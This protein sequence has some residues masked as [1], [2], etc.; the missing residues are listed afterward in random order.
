VKID[1]EIINIDGQPVFHLNLDTVKRLLE[2]QVGTMVAVEIRSPGDDLTR[3]VQL[4]RQA[5]PAT[6][7]WA[8]HQGTPYWY[9][10]ITGF[11]DTTPHYVDQ[12]IKDMTEK[13]AKGI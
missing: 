10:K 9:L 11:A 7:I 5:L 2:G 4:Q 12:A 6:V 3:T 13:G 8:P 1:D